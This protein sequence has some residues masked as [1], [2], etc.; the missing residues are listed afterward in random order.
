M[1]KTFILLITAISCRVALAQGVGMSCQYFPGVQ[2]GFVSVKKTA[3]GAKETFGAGLPI[4]LI[5]RIGNHWYSN[6]DFSALY[7]AATA[8]NKA[9]DDQIKISKAEGAVYAGRLGYLFGKGDQFRMGPNVN[10]GFMTSNLDASKRPMDH[11]FG[12]NKRTYY[13]F[14]LGVVAYKKFGKFRAAAK[15]GLEFY[16]RKNFL[17]K[18]GNGF[19]FEGTL[20]YSFYQKYGVSVMPCFYSKKLTYITPTSGAAGEEAKV[21]SMALKVGLSR[22]F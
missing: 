13:N 12:D 2:V 16:S 10:L 5:D 3:T 6:M 22:F 11:I 21:K 14:G 4:L 1:R 7:Y 8:T 17:A 18:R 15:L 20:G 9:N 19:Y